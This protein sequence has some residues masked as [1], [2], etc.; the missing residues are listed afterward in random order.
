MV[1]C[2]RCGSEKYLFVNTIREYWE[3]ESIT[4]EGNVELGDLNYEH[5]V[6][7]D[8]MR[9]FHCESCDYQRLIE[10]KNPLP[11]KIQLALQGESRG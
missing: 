8:A 11:M 2:P 3:V 9:F 7:G 4:P 6:E 5:E 1:T 10:T